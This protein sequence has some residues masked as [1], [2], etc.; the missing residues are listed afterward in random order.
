MYDLVSLFWFCFRTTLAIYREPS[1][2]Y[3]DFLD[4]FIFVHLNDQKP[5][6]GQLEWKKSSSNAEALKTTCQHS[7]RW[8]H[9]RAI[10]FVHQ[11]YCVH[12]G[13][14]EESFRNYTHEI[15]DNFERPLSQ[16]LSTQL[17]QHYIGKIC[18]MFYLLW[19][20]EICC[21]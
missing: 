17:N 2:L 6:A 8:N 14:G 13:K 9:S 4:V 12:F 15:V 11:Q 5:R 20:N 21:H 1:C 10:E 3:H 18:L 19:L 7:N 16:F